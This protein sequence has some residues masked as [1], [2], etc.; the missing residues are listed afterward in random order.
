MKKLN[1]FLFGQTKNNYYLQTTNNFCLQKSFSLVMGHNHSIHLLRVWTW[2]H[3]NRFFGRSTYFIIL[4]CGF[5]KSRSTNQSP[6]AWPDSLDLGS[7]KFINIRQIYIFYLLCGF[8]N[9]RT[10]IV[11]PMHETPFN[12]TMF[13]KPKHISSAD[14]GIL[15]LSTDCFS[16]ILIT[17]AHELLE[18][19]QQQTV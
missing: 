17:P 8:H 9:R 18:T 16:D 13:S 14:K 5:L 15:G 4:L 1:K 19:P 10:G 2:D 3:S 7:L 12:V 11:L 6:D